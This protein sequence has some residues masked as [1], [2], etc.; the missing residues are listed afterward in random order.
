[1]TPKQRL[2]KLFAQAFALFLIVSFA[3]LGFGIIDSLLG[4][5]VNVSPDRDSYGINAVSEL[6]TEID[7]DVSVAQLRIEE[8]SRLGVYAEGDSISFREDGN[9]LVI[10]DGKKISAVSQGLIII[11]VPEVTTFDSVEI[12]LGAGEIDVDFLN[13]SVLSLKLGGADVF[14]KELYV[15]TKAYVRCAAGEFTVKEGSVNNLEADFAV[16]DVD[17]RCDL[18]GSSEIDCAV[19]TVKLVLPDAQENYRISVDKG[20]GSATLNRKQIKDDT[21]CGSGD[22][23]IEIDSAAGSVSIKTQ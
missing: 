3:L 11:T 8:G 6:I 12:S 20:V 22:K 13:T 21:T 14:I 19:G 10:T 7:M 16:G 23:R 15:S 5:S 17:I 4:I 2:I 9:R 1:M 18:A